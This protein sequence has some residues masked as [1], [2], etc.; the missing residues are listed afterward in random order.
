MRY[1]PLKRVSK[2]DIDLRPPSGFGLE[3]SLPICTLSDKSFN[4]IL[5]GI[6]KIMSV[7]FSSWTI[8]SHRRTLRP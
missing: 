8:S 7:F 3:C 1:K 2:D 4:Q 5:K 6:E